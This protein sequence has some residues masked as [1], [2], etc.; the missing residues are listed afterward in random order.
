MADGI[1]ID[2]PDSSEKEE[3]ERLD[4]LPDDELRDELRRIEEEIE[5][6]RDEYGVESPE[7]LRE[8]IDETLP[9]EERE[10]RREDEYDW[11]HNDYTRD[12]ILDV[13]GDEEDS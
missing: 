1:D 8:S 11:R 12:L 9:V 5:G 6:W 4:E 3:R 10:R 7:D 2:W 13:L